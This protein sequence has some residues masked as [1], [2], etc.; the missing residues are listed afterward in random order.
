MKTSPLLGVVFAGILALPTVAFAQTS[1]PKATAPGPLT[2]VNTDTAPKA[3]GPYSQ[4]V[5]AGGFLF[6]S[7]QIPLDRRRGTSSAGRS[8]CRRIGSST[9]SK[10]S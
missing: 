10:R 2:F 8:R 4:A 3:I 9:A 5:V 1:A 7:G 6:A